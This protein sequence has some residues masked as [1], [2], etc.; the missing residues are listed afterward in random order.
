MKAMIFAAG[1]GTRLKPITN[2]IP[3]A[4]LPLGG[5]TLL[6]YQIERLKAAGIREMVVNVHHFAEMIIDYLRQNNNFGCDIQIS[7]ERECLLDTG[8]GLRKAKQLLG[9]ETVL[10][11]NVDILSNIDINHL[12]RAHSSDRLATLVVSERETQRYLLFDNNLELQGWTNIATQEVRPSGLTIRTDWRR[13]AFSGMQVLSPAIFDN[14]DAVVAA[15]G[16]K[17]SLIDLYLSLCSEHKIV[18]F[19]PTN[20]HMMDVGKI[21]HLQEA[22]EFMQNIQENGD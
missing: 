20:Y 7:D 17:F 9:D 21:D 22:E 2:N 5:K 19:V 4:L 3:K 11:C 13:L 16:E 15:K 10:A 18:A 1:L 14:M 6:Q 12:M 8:G